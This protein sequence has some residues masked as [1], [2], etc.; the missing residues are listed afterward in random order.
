MVRFI[1]CLALAIAVIFIVVAI[2]GGNL[3]ALFAL[4]PFLLVVLVPL[5]SSLAVYR[6]KDL[7]R[8]FRDVFGKKKPSGQSQEIC[9]FYEKMFIV[10]GIIG[11]LLGIIV[12]LGNMRDIAKIGSPLA[13]TLLCPLYAAIF[14]MVTRVWR[15]KLKNGK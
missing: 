12:T 8:A 15:M 1:T 5:L 2:E 3:L 10:T 4:S 6:P 14:Y 7:L 9:R 13:V 11:T